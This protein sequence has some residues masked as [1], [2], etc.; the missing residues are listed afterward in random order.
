MSDKTEDKPTKKKGKLGLILIAVGMLA[1]GGGGTFALFRAGMIGGHAEEK[2]EAGP[3]LI[4]KGEKDPYAPPKKEGEAEG[5]GAEVEGGG[6]DEFRTAYYT[7]SEA[8]T[9][10]LKDTDSL[11]QISLACSTQ[12]DGRVL[13]WLG[14]HELA[15][16]SRLLAILADTPEEQ[17]ISME[18]KDRLQKRM[19][20]A[21]NQVLVQKEGFGGVDAVYFRSFIIQ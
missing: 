13:T 10:N 15:I 14:K 6:G 11:I 5:G 16:R 18:G 12:R 20:A 1:V 19:T 8:F 2:K 7:F 9:S 17:I 4:R 21:I 3:Q